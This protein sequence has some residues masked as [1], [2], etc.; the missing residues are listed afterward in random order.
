MLTKLEYRVTKSNI[1][2]KLLGANTRSFIFVRVDM[3]QE[4]CPQGSGRRSLRS[5]CEEHES[6]EGARFFVPLTIR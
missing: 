5:K 1:D 3:R 2:L 4:G 6:A